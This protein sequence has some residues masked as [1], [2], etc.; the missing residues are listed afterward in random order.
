MPALIFYW[1]PTQGAAATTPDPG[2]NPV[3]AEP[4]VIPAGA[5]PAP[6][7][8]LFAVTPRGGKPILYRTIGTKLQALEPDASGVALKDGLYAAHPVTGEEEK[9]KRFLKFT[10]DG[11]CAPGMLAT[12]KLTVFFDRSRSMTFHV[13]GP[14]DRLQGVL[15]YQELPRAVSVGREATAELSE[16]SGVDVELGKQRFEM[17]E[18]D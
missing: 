1:T 6:I 10:Q 3:P 14:Y 5:R 7:T 2:P 18:V 8:G 4:D 16:V 11:T 9:T 17:T 15:F 12:A 13:R